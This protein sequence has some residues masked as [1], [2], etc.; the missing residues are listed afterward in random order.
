MNNTASWDAG[1]VYNG[2]NITALTDSIFIDN[3][4]SQAW[5]GAIFNNGN[6]IAL[7]DSTFNGNTA[8]N[9]GAI[10]MSN[11]NLTVHYSSFVNNT[12]TTSGNAIYNS[13]YNAGT[14]NAEYNWWGSNNNPSSQIYGTVDY[15]NWLYMTITIDPTTITNGST[16]TVTVSFNNVCNGTNVTGIDPANGHIP[17]GT[18][19]SFNSVLGTFN[20]AKAV[21]NNGNA[22]S[23][24]T[25]ADISIKT[26]NAVSDNQTVSTYINGI[27]TEI[28]V[29]NV[30]CSKGSTA[31]LTATLTSLNGT[32]VSGKTVTFIVNGTSYNATT[33]AI[34][35][36]NLSY[37]PINAGIYSVTASFAGDK[38]YG[39]CS[40]TGYLTAQMN[41]VYVSP[42]GSDTDGDGTE[43]NPF[44][45]IQNGLNCVVT[46]GTLH[47]MAGT[48]TGTG[49]NGLNL[50]KNV[51]IVGENQNNTLINAAKSGN[52]FTVNSGLTVKITNLTLTNGIATNGG[53]I[54]NNGNL[55]ITNCTF[56]NN[57]A[58]N[59]G[60]AIYDYQSNLTLS[61]CTFT[62][63]TASIS[64]G[65]AIYNYQSNLTLSGCIFTSNTASN[66]GGAICNAYGSSLNM[67]N[68]TFSS[69]AATNQGGAIANVGINAILNGSNCIF[70][71]NTA[72]TDGGAIYNNG[73]TT[74]HFNSFVN[75]TA[76]TGSD[77][78]LSMGTVNA[79]NNWWGSNNSPLSQIYVDNGTVDYSNWLYMTIT[80][81]NIISNGT[82]RTMTVSFNNVYNGTN[83]TSIDPANGHIPD[84]TVVS[85]SSA[86]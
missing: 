56:T 49:N 28:S 38:S 82:T 83:V 76:P 18:V 9:G 4:A 8:A 68:C 55:T 78:Y 6:I 29:D 19:V 66:W 71:N 51:N 47:L 36:A 7:T 80:N 27:G 2:G 60:G 79:Q 39:D 10:Y 73:I 35:V 5:G 42:T 48:Y 52:I 22:T 26:V 72:T 1:A 57:K 54:Y 30:T 3:T 69:N 40:K 21:T 62:D 11:G 12:A 31:N 61:G 14:V 43:S 84:G 45:T 53:A 46:S 34:G 75:N 86:L 65:G 70:S 81:Q 41:D 23:T 59:Q 50:T 32:G 67:S 58:T 33:D 85:F 63:N 24:F 44:A 25:A 37:E 20:P 13:I 64:F 15:S 17:N 16:G 77:I 74:L